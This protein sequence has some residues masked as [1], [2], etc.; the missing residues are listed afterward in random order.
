MTQHRHRPTLEK[1]QPTNSAFH[2]WIDSTA[3]ATRFLSDAMQTSNVPFAKQTLYKRLR[4]GAKYKS[5]K[6]C[7]WKIWEE[8]TTNRKQ[9]TRTPQLKCRAVGGSSGRLEPASRTFTWKIWARLSMASTWMPPTHPFQNASAPANITPRREKSAL[10][11][12]QRSTQRP[13][14]GRH[15]TKTFTW[16]GLGTG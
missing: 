10:R 4:L 1:E 5:R 11:Q 8:Q 9:I 14:N 6:I 12:Y 2:Q 3:T 13:R 7:F 16:T 15:S